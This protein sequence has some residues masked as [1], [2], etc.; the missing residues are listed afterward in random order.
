MVSTRSMRPHRLDLWSGFPVLAS[1]VLS[2]HG[3]HVGSLGQVSVCVCVRGGGVA[4]NPGHLLGNGMV[5]HLFMRNLHHATNQTQAT[6]RYLTRG[7]GPRDNASVGSNS[8]TNPSALVTWLPDASHIS[9]P[10]F[11]NSGVS[12]HLVGNHT[13]FGGANNHSPMNKL[14]G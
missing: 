7:S 11:V 6:R 13:T 12:L 14:V 10:Q 3:S 9:Q 2:W 4:I 8:K 1:H 5:V